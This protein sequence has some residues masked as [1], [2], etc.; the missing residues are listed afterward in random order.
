MILY[1]V[2]FFLAV[3][4][5]SGP[6]LVVF[7]SPWEPFYSSTSPSSSWSF[8]GSVSRPDSR[9]ENGSH[10]RKNDKRLPNEWR[11]GCRCSSYSA[12]RGQQDTS[13][14][15][16]MTSPMS[17]SSPSMPSR[18]SSSFSCS[19]CGIQS[20]VSSGYPFVQVLVNRARRQ[21]W[22]FPLLRIV[23]T[24]KNSL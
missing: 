13:P 16:K 6:W 14:F 1:T 24:P 11:L 12:S 9:G 7:S 19:A 8:T 20:F 15:F 22:D 5:T 18:A 3:T 23:E 10:V 2:H 4:S 17:Y 21:N